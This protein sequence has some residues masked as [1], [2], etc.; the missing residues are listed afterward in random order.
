M[1]STWPSGSGCLVGRSGPYGLLQVWSLHLSHRFRRLVLWLVLSLVL[2]LVLGN[3]RRLIPQRIASFWRQ[4]R[5]ARGL[6]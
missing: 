5:W 6:A 4:L 2:G 3:R 1:G